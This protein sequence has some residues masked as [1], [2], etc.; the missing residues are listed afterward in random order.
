MTEKQDLA[1][2]FSGFTLT[3][4]VIIMAIVLILGSIAI[5]KYSGTVEKGRSAEAY[6]VLA[7]IAAAEKAYRMEKGAYTTAWSDLDRYD[8]AP[9]SENFTYSLQSN[10]FARA[11]QI[12]GKATNCYQMCFDGSRKWQAT[13]CSDYVC[14]S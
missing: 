7:D 8:S 14:P 5:T 11:T 1:K 4:L 2:K 3:E 10:R 6:A 12:A 9:V 13:G